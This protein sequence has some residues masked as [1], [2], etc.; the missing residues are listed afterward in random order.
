MEIAAKKINNNKFKTYYG[1]KGLDF[2]NKKSIP[3]FSV[4][5]LFVCVLCWVVYFEYCW[6]LWIFL[7]VAQIL[8]L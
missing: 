3:E 5:D 8:G 7:A 4:R 6:T 1:H 2:P